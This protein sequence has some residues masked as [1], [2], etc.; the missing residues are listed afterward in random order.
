MIS[1]PRKKREEILSKLGTVPA[2]PAAAMRAVRLMQDPDVSVPSLV[3]TIEY[4]A[5]LT[6]GV[7]QHANSPFF[8]GTR[9]VP[10]VKDA[11]VRLGINNLRKV[12]LAAAFEPMARQQILG[13]DMPAGSLWEHSLA[14]AVGVDKL[15]KAAGLPQPPYAFTAAILIDVGKI[16]LGT[17]IKV[18]P[19]P[20]MA[21]AYD[22]NLSFDAAERE[23]LG[24]DHA[25]VGA[26]LLEAWNLPPE[27]VDVVRWHH[28]PE[29]CPGD[30]TAVDL[31]HLA[32]ALAVVIGIG[33]GM[34]GLNYRPS[35]DAAA[36]FN[37]PRAER[38]RVALELLEELERLR[39]R[40]STAA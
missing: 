8:G 1:D 37:L 19:E 10:T 16:V 34:D 12:V 20:L 2:L 11:V 4:D 23:V 30:R 39:G 40:L 24:I 28:Q 35:P 7:L 13:Y 15:C 22:Q 29:S 31:V 26:A 5:S 9:K 33:G 14:V 18:D 27:V 38:E 36:R 6:A 25:E 21:V 17:F 32:D 3:T